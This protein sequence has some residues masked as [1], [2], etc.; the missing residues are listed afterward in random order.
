VVAAEIDELGA[1]VLKLGD[2]RAIVLFA[3]IDPFEQDLGPATVS[4]SFTTWAKPF[5]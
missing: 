1:G 3:R 2:D 4:L 5:P